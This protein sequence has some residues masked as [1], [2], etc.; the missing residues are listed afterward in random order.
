MKYLSKKNVFNM[1]IIFILVIFA[2]NYFFWFAI[3]KVSWNSMY[4]TFKNKE[5]FIYFKLVKYIPSLI[6]YNDVLVYSHYYEDV[7][8]INFIKRVK[9]KPGDLVFKRQ[10]LYDCR[11]K[12]WHFTKNQ[13]YLS[14]YFLIGDNKSKSLDSRYCFSYWWCKSNSQWYSIRLREID[15]KVIFKF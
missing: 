5:Y 12:T 2:L 3:G 13:L 9:C 4:P 10:S 8:K 11:K 6:N 1:F 14:W 7:W 15:W